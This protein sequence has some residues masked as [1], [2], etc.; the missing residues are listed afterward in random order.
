MV[1]LADREDAIRGWQEVLEA[2]PAWWIASESAPA[3]VPKPKRKTKQASLFTDESDWVNALAT[4][5]VFRQQIELP[6]NRIKPEQIADALR[7]LDS[8]GGHGSCALSL[9]RA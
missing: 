4:N 8:G 9:P 2:R 3:E 5:A 6:G 7:S 1:V